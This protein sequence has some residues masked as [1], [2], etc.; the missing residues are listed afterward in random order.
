MFGHSV[1]A[2]A[3]RGKVEASV[4]VIPWFPA[5]TGGAAHLDWL[6]HQEVRLQLTK[7][8]VVVMWC[9]FF[10]PSVPLNNI[11]LHPDIAWKE[12]ATRAALALDGPF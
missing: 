8:S 10:L 5:H 3:F 4:I 9:S 1:W 6:S 12:S 2:Y 7:G 11:S